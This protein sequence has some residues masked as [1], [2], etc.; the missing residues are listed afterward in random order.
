MSLQEEFLRRSVLVLGV[1]KTGRNKVGK[2][3]VA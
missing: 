2:T 3:E 1:G